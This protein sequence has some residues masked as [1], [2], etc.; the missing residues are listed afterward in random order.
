MAEQWTV[1][2]KFVKYENE[3]TKSK[4]GEGDEMSVQIEPHAT[5]NMLKQRIG[6]IC[7]AHPKH[8][9]VAFDGGHPLDD[10]AK[11]QDVPGLAESQC[12]QV[13]V[14]V[15]AGP[16]EEAVVLSE[17]EGLFHGEE[18][19]P[20]GTPGDDIIS[21][22]LSDEEMDRQ[23][24]LKGQAQDL[25]EDG[26]LAGAVA[27]FTEAVM[28]GGVSAMMMAKRAEMLLKQKRYHAAIA[29]A[30]LALRLN[31]DSAKA[32]KVRGKARRFI[33]DYQGSSEDLSV[34]Q[35]IDFDDGVADMH[36]YVQKRLAR[37]Q[38]KAKQEAAAEG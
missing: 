3:S 2:L 22:E 19:D 8:Q 21:K 25:L 14:V 38:V 27:K 5:V 33:G 26:D 23:G 30:T 16:K 17:D 20:P 9:Q 4:L 11:L 13:S 7:M 31:P 24:A 37:I 12:L 1:K 18:A 35:K 28:L 36:S 32:F 6:L 15:P 29:D 10:V 34:A